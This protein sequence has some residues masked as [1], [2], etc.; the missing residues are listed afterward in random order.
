VRTVALRHAGRRHH[1]YMKAGAG[2]LRQHHRFRITEDTLPPYN[3]GSGMP[4]SGE[5]VLIAYLR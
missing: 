3:R 1:A 4:R 2:E 5:L